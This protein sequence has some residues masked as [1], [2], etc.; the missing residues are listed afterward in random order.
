MTISKKLRKIVLVAISMM[1]V[2]PVA[3]QDLLANQAPI[4]RKMKAVDAMMLQQLFVKR[5]KPVHP[6]VTC[7]FICSG[8][9]HRKRFSGDPV[10]NNPLTPAVRDQ[11][12]SFGRSDSQLPC[13]RRVAELMLNVFC[14][15][16]E[17]K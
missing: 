1:A 5:D 12:M 16:P 3:A 8:K 11:L 17:I 6:P 4:D 15:I 9:F 2:T 10:I 7:C 14:R 13:Y